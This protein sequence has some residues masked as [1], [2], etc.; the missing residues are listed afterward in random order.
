MCA[1]CVRYSDL[2][3]LSLAEVVAARSLPHAC[4]AFVD[5]VD[6]EVAERQKAQDL[7]DAA[8]ENL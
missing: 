7:D 2:R 5:A 1:H 4:Q 3:A 6:R 8:D